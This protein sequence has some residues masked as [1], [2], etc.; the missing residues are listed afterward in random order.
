MVP[1]VAAAVVRHK[2]DV[3]YTNTITVCVG[4]FA[5]RLVR[6]PHVWHIHEFVYEHHRL[7]FDLGP[8]I[9]LRLVNRLSS[10]CIANSRAVAEGFR[11]QIAPSKLKV[12]YQSVTIPQGAIPRTLGAPTRIGEGIVCVMVGAL[13]KGK[14]QEDAILAV[15]DLAPTGARA[16]LLIIG[17]GVPDYRHYLHQLVDKHNLADQV[18]FLGYVEK[19]WE[20]I[21][22]A[23]VV[24]MCSQNEGFGRVTVEAM[25]LGKPVIGAA[26]GGTVELIQDGINGYLYTLGNHQELAEK[27][28]YLAS[29][30]DEA[31]RMGRNGQEWAANRFTQARYGEEVLSIL[32]RVT[33]QGAWVAPRPGRSRDVP[34]GKP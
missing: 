2:C 23:D 24:L 25:L 6:R 10:A 1:H 19:P 16:H 3:V 17:D 13:Q 29:H 33:R 15:A 7:A 22:R 26:S 8:W 32:K 4:A 34:A 5:A 31:Q 20:L 27:I 28:E 30:P 21:H 14:R 9:S 18:T 11:G 12:V